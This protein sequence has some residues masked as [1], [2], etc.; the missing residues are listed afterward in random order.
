MDQE[1][2]IKFLILWTVNTLLLLIFAALFANDIVLGNAVM[3]KPMASVLVGLILTI[4]ISLV[5]KVAKKYDVKIKDEKIQTSVYFFVDLVSIW[6]LKRLAD[7]TG[8]GISNI[9]WVL[10]LAIIVAL[11]QVGVEKYS[12]Q[13]LKKN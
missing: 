11:V 13:L 10:I 7:F 8:L 5:P 3:T 4:L 1:K 12:T 9:L 2:L 6:I